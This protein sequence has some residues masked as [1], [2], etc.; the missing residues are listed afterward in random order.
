MRLY[1][2]TPLASEQP[3]RFYHLMLQSDLLQGWWVVVE[4]GQQGGVT[5][6]KRQYFVQED[7][8]MMAFEA[9]RDIQIA[10]GFRIMFAQGMDGNR[11]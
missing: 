1:M 4:S 11:G 5:R 7:E 6:V 8:A 10:K 3:P 2:Q 9:T